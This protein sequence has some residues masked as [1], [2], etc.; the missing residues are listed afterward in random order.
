MHTSLGLV[1]AQQGRLEEGLAE[2]ERAVALDATDGVAFGHL[3]DLYRMLGREEEAGW[4][5]REAERWS[6]Q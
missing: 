3:A 4:A 5:R 6:E 2:L 1:L